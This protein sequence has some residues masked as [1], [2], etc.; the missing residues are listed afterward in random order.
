M[1]LGLSDIYLT[2]A[3]SANPSLQTMF[4]P[5]EAMNVAIDSLKYVNGYH[6]LMWTCI[7]AVKITFLVFFKQFVDKITLWN[8]RVRV[9]WFAVLALMV[10]G[11]GYMLG[12]PFMVCPHSGMDVGKCFSL[13]PIRL[14]KFK[15]LLTSWIV[16]H[17]SGP[18]KEDLARVLA[19]VG[20]TVD[21]VTDALVVSFPVLI[22]YRVHITLRQKAA[23]AAL[24]CL[25][26]AMI[27]IAILRGTLL[28][29]PDKSA[30][31]GP[32]QTYLTYVEG[33]VAV[34][35]VSV[36]A[37]RSIFNNSETT[38]NSIEM[39]NLRRWTPGTLTRRSDQGVGSEEQLHSTDSDSSKDKLPGL[40]TFVR[41]GTPNKA[42]RK[43]SG[44]VRNES[45]LRTREVVV[46]VHYEKDMDKEDW[47]RI[48]SPSWVDEKWMRR[49]SE[50]CDFGG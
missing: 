45:V 37:F 30:R 25:S 48:A 22:L 13:T 28:K 43:G 4:S 26:V 33:C 2:T 20:T 24:T 10:A 38:P 46:E 27:V 7:F 36:T 21:C 35:A 39:P 47:D 31:D 23:V 41:G 32:V 29:N 11:W 44:L 8:A 50:S 9:Y 12:V 49:S 34:I 16:K 6:C 14:S 3:I 19:Y 17:C 18:E 1:H 42:R 40:Q 15:A 5:E